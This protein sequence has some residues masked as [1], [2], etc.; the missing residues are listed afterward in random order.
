MKCDTY[1]GFYAAPVL[2]STGS[3]EK[4]LDHFTH[5]KIV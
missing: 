2:V 1:E 4:Y 3:A 5:A